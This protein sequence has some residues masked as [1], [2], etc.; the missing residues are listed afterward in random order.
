MHRPQDTASPPRARRLRGS[1]RRQSV[2]AKPGDV[3]K[4]YRFGL[5]RSAP[6]GWW[7]KAPGARGFNPLPN[8]ASGGRR[9]SDP[10]RTARAISARAWGVPEPAAERLVPSPAQGARLPW[11]DRRAPRKPGPGGPT[12]AAVGTLPAQPP[13]PRIR[14]PADALPRD[15][16][17]TSMGPVRRGADRISIVTLRA[18]VRALNLLGRRGGYA[19]G[20]T[21]IGGISEPSWPFGDF[22]P[23]R[24]SRRA[25]VVS[26]G[27]CPHQAT[28]A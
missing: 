28:Y 7:T 12:T 5:G 22:A 26:F 6:R 27:L 2:R 11:R 17:R 9:G 25:A 19:R 4:E 8:S 21:G 15:G 24:P 1:G 23:E 18:G 14:S 20:G 10:D 13:P 3:I 16:A